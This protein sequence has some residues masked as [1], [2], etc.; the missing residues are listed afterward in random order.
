MY[1]VRRRGS[2]RA[3]A[4]RSLHDS[5]GP[6]RAAALVRAAGMLDRT[7][8]QP[9]ARPASDVA[10]GVADHPRA[11]RGRCRG[12]AAASSS[13]PGRRLAAVARPGQLRRRRR[14]D[15]AGRAGTASKRDAARRRAARARAPGRPASCAS[16]DRALRGRRLVGDADQQPARR[17][18]GGA[19]QPA[20]PAISATSSTRSGDSGPAADRVGDELVDHA[21][22]VDEHRRAVVAHGRPRPVREG[23]RPIAGL[24]CRTDHRSAAASPGPSPCADACGSSRLATG[25][26]GR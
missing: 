19:A 20:A 5:V 2:M 14:R 21:V 25:P 10:V 12:R 6:Q 4:A 24:A 22:A 17:R 1:S 7:V 16:D 3:A 8:R 26:I 18:P 11:R 9:A 15:G 23:S 13:M